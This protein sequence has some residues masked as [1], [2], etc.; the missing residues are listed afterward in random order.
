MS[1]K[2][3]KI[4][5]IEDELQIRKLLKIILKDE[6]CIV[7]ECSTGNSGLKMALANRHDL[8]ILDLGL[9]DLDGINV[10][11][12]IREFSA[13]PIIICSVRQKDE[14]IIDALKIG[15]DDY[16][17]KPFNPEILVARVEAA[18]RRSVVEISKTKTLQN[19]ELVLD[20]V[21]R[22]VF[23]AK[24]LLKLSPKEFD[25]L[26]YFLNNLNKAL[27]H[28]Q[29]LTEI[30]GPANAED[31]QYLRVYINQLR[32]KIEQDPK[33]PQYIINIPGVGYKMEKI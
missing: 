25:L 24:K 31:M 1:N 18:L 29:I 22:D 17:T 14:E 9:P 33:C 2:K 13:I 21:S 20:L 6:G 15:A 28:R 30:W 32:N 5:V 11:E 26:K 7:D 12:R 8:I 23:L 4:L 27:T 16:L 10:L 19:S 3:N